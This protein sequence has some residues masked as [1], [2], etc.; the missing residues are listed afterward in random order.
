MDVN[1]KKER[2]AGGSVYFSI[3]YDNDTCDGNT[4]TLL[5]SK[6][7]HCLRI[8]YQGSCVKL[9]QINTMAL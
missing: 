4:P 6:Q 2:T 3:Y 9:L 1:V 8:H 7:E 5:H